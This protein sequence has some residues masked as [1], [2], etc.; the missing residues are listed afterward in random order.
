[1]KT[2]VFTA[3]VLLRG[4]KLLLLKRKEDDDT[5]PGL[6]DLPGGHLE[7]GE[8][9]DA[10]MIREA[11]EETGL[12]VEVVRPGGLVEYTD[13]YGRSIEFP[14]LLRSRS[15]RVIVSEH[16]GFRWVR[17]RALRRYHRVPGMDEA[18]IELG[19]VS[20]AKNVRQPAANS[21]L[22]QTYNE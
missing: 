12:D 16:S 2:R 9:A 19:L 8:S 7:S 14:F 17:P 1:M 20:P 3:G 11:K 22:P 5:Y 10:C 18:L 21:G 6:W 4:H 13:G 15:G